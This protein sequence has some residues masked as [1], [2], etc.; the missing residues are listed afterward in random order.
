MTSA[1]TSKVS[2][3][4]IPLSAQILTNLI[5]YAQPLRNFL[6]K[7][8]HLPQITL[9]PS[10]KAL[11]QQLQ[12]IPWQDT[13][14]PEAPYL[15]EAA[16]SAKS[17]H[18]VIR[19]LRITWGYGLR[20]TCL[21]AL[22]VEAINFTQAIATKLDKNLGKEVEKRAGKEVQRLLGKELKIEAGKELG[23]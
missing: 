4:L 1:F 9:L 22:R 20:F 7:G 5:L 21:R 6:R 8:A 23:K 12:D 16:E 14:Q 3:C 19:A 11:S 15:A 13:T 18:Y 10:V 2:L 17:D